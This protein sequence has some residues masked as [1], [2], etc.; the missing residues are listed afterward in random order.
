MKNTKLFTKKKS[1]LFVHQSAD[2]YG[3]DRVLLALVS[4]L[5]REKFIP[6]VLLP[7]DGPLVAELLAAGVECHVV[8]ITR[9]SRA[10]LSLRGLLGLPFNLL[11]SMRAMDRVLADRAIDIVHSNTLAVL[12]SPIW[13]RWHRVPHIWHVHEI[14]V[15]PRFVRKAYTYLLSWFADCIVCVSQAAK[16]NLVQDKPALAKKINV[17]WN[18]LECSSLVNGD[19]A[20]MYREQIGL[21]ENEVLVALVGRIN[22]LKGQTLLVEAAG[23]L[24]QQ[25]V[26]DVRYVL[27]GSAPEG[28]AHFFEKLQHAINQS[29]AKAAFSL[30]GFTNDVWL[31]WEA[32]DIAVIP[33]TEPESFGL[34]ALEAMAAAKP[35]IA[36]NHGGLTEIV[37]SSETGLLVTPGSASELADAIKLLVAG[38]PLRKKMGEAGE[39]RYRQE[40]TLDRHVENMVKVY[41]QIFQYSKRML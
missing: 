38:A 3:S 34:V 39:L 5:D 25:G 22:R 13:A 15:N 12:S 2:L 7:V 10:T 18:G 40:F 8:E 32:C 19:A 31:V 41:E 20:R 36:A 21:G 6:I 28:Q 37:V 33:S 17:V 24:W 29:P 27:V 4:K 9:L 23:L 35:V 16:E 11:K 14:I 30:Q 1:I 26:R